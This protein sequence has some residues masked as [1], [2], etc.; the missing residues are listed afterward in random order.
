M[1]AGARG[2]PL[3]AGDLLTLGSHVEVTEGATFLHL[4][5][6][7]RRSGLGRFDIELNRSVLGSSAPG[8]GGPVRRPGDVLI[9]L[10][11][12]ARVPAVGLFQ[13]EGA[14]RSR[15]AAFR[16]VPCWSRRS[17]LS[18]AGGVLAAVAFND[19]PIA[20][21]ASDGL[22]PLPERTFA[23]ASFDLSAFEPPGACFS[24]GSVTVTSRASGPFA[25]EARDLIGPLPTLISTCAAGTP[26]PLQL[27]P[28]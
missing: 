22:G 11:L 1:P 15:C 17:T 2:A 10:D 23:E 5:W 8:R 26:R 24:F 4:F 25:R 7:V 21:A 28:S 6:R 18:R 27:A 20:A 14:D 13:W 12:S 3:G 16:A 19:A 9:S